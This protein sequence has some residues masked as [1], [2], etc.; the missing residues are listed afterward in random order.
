M[1]SGDECFTRRLIS[2]LGKRRAQGVMPAYRMA[3]LP[4]D[5]GSSVGVLPWVETDPRR[6]GSSRR[7]SGARRVHGRCGPGARKGAGG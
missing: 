3:G 5:E 6:L 1:T 4:E 7:G 2:T